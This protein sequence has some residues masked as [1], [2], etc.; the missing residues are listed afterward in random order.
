MPLPRARRAG[1]ALPLQAEPPLS[2]FHEGEREVQ[3]RAGVRERIER[4]GGRF[5]RQFMPDQH[6]E[7]FAQLP[8]LLVG[9]IDARGRPW[10]SML[11]GRPGFVASPDPATLVVT[12]EP[13]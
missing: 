11:A 5:V 7:L 10:A 13:A 12:A 1:S 2:P 8:M 6:R 4:A 3:A 9:S